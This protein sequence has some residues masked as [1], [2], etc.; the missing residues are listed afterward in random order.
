MPDNIPIKSSVSVKQI[1]LG[2]WDEY[3]LTHCVENYQKKEDLVL[4]IQSGVIIKGEISPPLLAQI[5]F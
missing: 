3:L 1:L 4:T 5:M 2:S